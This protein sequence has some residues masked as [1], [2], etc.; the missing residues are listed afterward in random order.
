MA[1]LELNLPILDEIKNRL[2]VIDSKL[3]SIQKSRSLSGVWLTT[4]EAAK[5]LQVTPRTLQNYRD[6]GEI[7]FT[8]FGR[9]IRFRAEDIQAFLLEHYVNPFKEERAGS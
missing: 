4:K 7:P 9:E 6:R 2:E 3:E 1:Q 5:A 8:Q